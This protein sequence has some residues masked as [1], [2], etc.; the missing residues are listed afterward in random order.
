MKLGRRI[1]TA[2]YKKITKRT[3]RTNFRKNTKRRCK[4]YRH[5]KTHRK[6]SRKLKYN[7]R[8][9]MG[10]EPNLMLKEYKDNNVVLTHLR[11]FPL[12]NGTTVYK[13]F[14][15]YFDN[16]SQDVETDIEIILTRKYELT[17]RI[18]ND[19]DTFVINFTVKITLSKK[20]KNDMYQYSRLTI[21]TTTDSG[22]ANIVKN[23]R[24]IQCDSTVN[25]NTIFLNLQKVLSFKVNQS[26]DR[27]LFPLTSKKNAFF[28]TK[29][30]QLIFKHSCD[31]TTTYINKHNESRQKLNLEEKKK[32]DETAANVCETLK[33]DAE[34]VPLYKKEPGRAIT[35][36]E[37]V[38]SQ[39]NQLHAYML[40]EKCAKYIKTHP[41][42]RYMLLHF[43][44][45]ICCGMVKKTESFDHNMYL[46]MQ[47]LNKCKSIESVKTEKE[48]TELYLKDAEV[49]DKCKIVIR[50]DYAEDHN[51]E[52]SKLMRSLYLEGLRELFTSPKYTKIKSLEVTEINKKD[53]LP[54][55]KMNFAFRIFYEIMLLKKYR[56]LFTDEGYNKKLKSLTDELILAE[57]ALGIDKLNIQR[58]EDGTREDGTREDGTR[59]DGTR[60][61]GTREDGTWVITL[62][63]KY[64]DNI[65]IECKTKKQEH[66]ELEG[67]ANKNWHI[68]QTRYDVY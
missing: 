68:D 8:G 61:D 18:G 12:P 11:S 5:K 13:Y 17:L 59:E 3:K 22:D 6:Y 9:Q 56:E 35:R 4:Q 26:N 32:E 47:N 27:R 34:F 43:I 66:E 58:A 52:Y 1:K 67:N 28:F 57:T 38:Y 14:L 37:N 30:V 63:K 25:N 45:N 62:V 64:L 24:V 48:L 44:W 10:G 54:Y 36:Y 7:K 15:K 16:N 2:R 31:K 49:I 55:E 19:T 40:E 46:F 65:P 51:D 21:M 20:S 50:E 23:D 41:S 53:E 33:L 29:V 42:E 60:E 39:C